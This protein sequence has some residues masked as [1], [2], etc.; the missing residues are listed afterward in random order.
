MATTTINVTAQIHAEIAGGD[1][2]GIAHSAV[3]LDPLTKSYSS[4]GDLVT[5]RFT[6]FNNTGLKQ[7]EI[8]ANG[9]NSRF[10][11]GGTGSC[12]VELYIEDDQGNSD[13]DTITITLI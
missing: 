10:I 1:K 7:P 9:K 2:T 12:S 3:I 6:I 5:Y 8:L 11:A 4:V 13:T